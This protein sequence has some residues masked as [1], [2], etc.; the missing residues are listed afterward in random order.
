MSSVVISGDTS[1][2]ITLSAPAV[3]GTNTI[4]LPAATG[5]VMVSGNQPAFSAYASGGQ[6]ISNNTATKIQFNTET[7]DTASA[8]DNATNYRFTPLVAGYYQ[9]ILNVALNTMT[10]NAQPSIWKSGAV[11]QYGNFPNTCTAS[12]YWASMTALIYMNGSTDYL[13]GY[14][15]QFSGGSI[16]LQTS[17]FANTF[18]AVL[19]RGA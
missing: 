3:A 2:A 4:T 15:T 5:T 1:G 12:P 10:G 19:V 16:A 9:V 14:I 6:S 11:Y 13:E 8:Y 17:S 18:S 7:F